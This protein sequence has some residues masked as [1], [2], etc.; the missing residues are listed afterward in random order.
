MNNLAD[1]YRPSYSRIRT[2]DAPRA[3]FSLP[4]NRDKKWGTGGGCTQVARACKRGAVSRPDRADRPGKRLHRAV[5]DRQSRPPARSSRGRTSS[6]VGARVWQPPQVGSGTN[7]RRHL[8]SR[9]VETSRPERAARRRTAP[10]PNNVFSRLRTTPYAFP[11][12]MFY[13]HPRPGGPDP[14]TATSVTT[15]PAISTHPPRLSPSLTA[16]TWL[17]TIGSRSPPRP[18]PFP[19]HLYLV[20][21]WYTKYS[22]ILFINYQF[23][24]RWSLDSVHPVTGRSAFEF[25]YRAIINKHS[26]VF[27]PDC[28]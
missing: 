27:W 12:S 2:V 9:C 4:A 5:G 10:S 11:T 8:W 6:A 23:K 7:S 26:T 3:G 16:P 22:F 14:G 18:S 25:K 13:D 28:I 24:N 17:E 21:N 19:S 20:S 15:T 1:G